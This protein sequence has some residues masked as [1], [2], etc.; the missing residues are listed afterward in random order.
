MNRIVIV[1]NGVDL[2]YGLKT[3]Y[4]DFVVKLIK[5]AINAKNSRQDLQIDNLFTITITGDFGLHYDKIDGIEKIEEFKSH[6]VILSDFKPKYYG[7]DAKVNGNS[8]L[9]NQLDI[10]PRKGSISI[11]SNSD[12]FKSV[13]SEK[14]WSDIERV[15][16]QLLNHYT[17]VYT[18][19]QAKAENLPQKELILKKY[20]TSI[21][22]LNL[23]F[24]KVKNEF[25]RYLTGLDKSANKN[26]SLDDLLWK[27]VTISKSL[28]YTDKAT[29]NRIDRDLPSFSSI[30]KVIFVDF[31]YTEVLQEII[32]K[33]KHHHDTIDVI[34]IPI[35]GT[36]NDSGSIIFGYG[37]ENNELY[38]KLEEV[39][40]DSL[41]THFKSY[42]YHS[43]S[44]YSTLIDCLHENEYDVIV[45]GHSLG[46]SDKLLLQTIFEHDQ[47][48][49][50]H[51]VHSGDDSHFR[52]RIAL[53]RHFED[54]KKMRDRLLEENPLLKIERH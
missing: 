45:I 48:K 40:E 16:F 7:I 33:I 50:I 49:F 17:D 38:R 51:L 18:K 6:N 44:K 31:N 46:L 35:H 29:K 12:F 25:I 28:Y 10:N 53:S 34:H 47:C 54:K 37:D 36:L 24:E 14:N 20:L 32:V 9:S 4:E 11:N 2:A 21:T 43:R 26:R 30:D 22:S 15:Y 13:L 41:L 23:D 19:G 5:E 3:R 42:Y 52:K 27:K 1:G 39:G 8:I